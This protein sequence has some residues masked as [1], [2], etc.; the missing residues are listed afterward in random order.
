MVQLRN[1]GQLTNDGVFLVV[2]VVLVILFPIFFVLYRLNYI[3]FLPYE[4]S[5]IN[6]RNPS[7]YEN[8]IC[9]CFSPLFQ[10]DC[11]CLNICPDSNN[12]VHSG[13]TDEIRKE[14]QREAQRQSRKTWPAGLFG[15]LIVHWNTCT[16]NAVINFIGWSYI[17][18][19][20]WKETMPNLLL[21]FSGLLLL[22]WI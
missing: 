17:C 19:T 3:V 18:L 8:H 13:L 2:A 14:V 12:K 4:H 7:I 1:N 9:K 11:E 15:W 21:L 22:L 16:S 6:G 5:N 20:R 10:W